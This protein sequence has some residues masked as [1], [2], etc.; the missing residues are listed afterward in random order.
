MKNKKRRG[1]F[2]IPAV[3]LVLAAC[4]TG[5]GEANGDSNT[6]DNS[7]EDAA[8]AEVEPMIE[9]LDENTYRYTLTNETEEAVT[10]EFTS[11]QRF[12]FSLTNNDGEQVFLLSS[13]SAYI[14]ALG[15]ETLEPDEELDYEFDVPELELEPGTYEL[16]AWLTPKEGPEYPVTAEHTI[17]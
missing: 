15:E 4:G 9:Q 14:Q 3:A 2:L 12:D 6:A 13:V 17:E 10:F 8:A 7:S 1:A 11:G 16:E 5:E